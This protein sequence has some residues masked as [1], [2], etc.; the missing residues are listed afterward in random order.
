MN[1][2]SKINLSN[3][4]TAMVVVSVVFMVPE[5]YAELPSITFPGVNENDDFVTK[6]VKVVGVILLALIYII[7][8]AIFVIAAWTVVSS[9]MKMASDRDQAGALAGKTIGAVVVAV[10]AFFFLSQAE[11]GVEL[12][13]NFSV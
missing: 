11:V 4:L 3:I 13:R 1:L 12:L 6:A 9:L 2:I 8:A 10:I 5:A 7:F